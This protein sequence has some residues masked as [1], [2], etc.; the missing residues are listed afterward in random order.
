MTTTDALFDLPRS[1][2]RDEVD[3]ILELMTLDPAHQQDR[4]RIV[5]AVVA[6]ARANRGVVDPNRV[7]A[8]LMVGGE[9]TVYSRV[10]GATF[11]ALKARRVLI[12][13]GHVRSENTKRGRNGGKV[14]PRYRLAAWV[15]AA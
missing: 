11:N 1:R 6:D 7:R 10:I 15:V 8:R 4:R 5:S 3:V 14:L 13:D 9:L 12:P 2:A